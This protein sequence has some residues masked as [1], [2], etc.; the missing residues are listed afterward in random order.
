MP[1][2]VIKLLKLKR[3][4]CF[5]NL[6]LGLLFFAQLSFGDV[7]TLTES[8][9]IRHPQSERRDVFGNTIS[10][11]AGR[12]L[13]T[14]RQAVV[15]HEKHENANTDDGYILQLNDFSHTSSVPPTKVGNTRF[16]NAG[17][18]V[19]DSVIG[20]NF[21]H[22]EEE[23]KRYDISNGNLLMDYFPGDDGKAL[24]RGGTGIAANEDFLLVGVPKDST[25]TSE[26][27]VAYLYSIHTG[28]PLFRLFAP[29]A[30]R[31][32]AFGTCVAISG[33]VLAVSAPGNK[34]RKNGTSI[35]NSGAVY[36]YDIKTGRFISKLESPDANRNLRFGMSLAVEGDTL[37]V[38]APGAGRGRASAHLFD[39]RTGRHLL[40]L[41]ILSPAEHRWYGQTVAI[42]QKF[43]L[44]S[45]GFHGGPVCVFDI[46][47]GRQRFLLQASELKDN[48]QFGRA[49]ALSGDTV[50]VGL[51]QDDEMG[52]AAGSVYIYDLSDE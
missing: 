9:I 17:I 49:I 40:G 15:R 42:G 45:D 29:D 4:F 35:E 26:A 47:S 18:L 39:I 7:L 3:F 52:L 13:I 25:I 22:F 34:Y 37:L 2:N 48:S 20:A 19:G 44:V 50:L 33:D 6:L 21:G 23:I 31:G 30:E 46:A 11:D 43:A 41:V 24:I 12:A 28:K 10:I 36:L 14:L 8:Q 5:N 38:G 32:A 1:I 27:G 51:P 16:I